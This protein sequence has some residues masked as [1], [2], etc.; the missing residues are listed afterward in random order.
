MMIVSAG[1]VS[2]A[3]R[4]QLAITSSKGGVVMRQIEPAS[5]YADGLKPRLLR[6]ALVG[7]WS[8][9]RPM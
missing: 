2:V 6:P 8:S 9:S 7:N 1:T 5:T 4:E 3:A